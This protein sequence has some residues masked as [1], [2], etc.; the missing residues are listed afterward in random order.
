MAAALT[1][2][3]SEMSTQTS[4]SSVPDRYSQADLVGRPGLGE[5]VRVSGRRRNRIQDG[6]PDHPVV[7]VIDVMLTEIIRRRVG[8]HHRIGPHLADQGHQPAVNPGRLPARHRESPAS[9][10]C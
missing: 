5:I 3:V 7:P 8:R 10:G 6:P 4:G 1:S 2:I 9:D